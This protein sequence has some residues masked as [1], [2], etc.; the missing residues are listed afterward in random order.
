MQVIEAADEEEEERSPA[1]RPPGQ[2][3]NGAKRE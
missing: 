1:R 2:R 3:A